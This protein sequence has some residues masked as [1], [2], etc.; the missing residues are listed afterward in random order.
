MMKYDGKEKDRPEACTKPYNEITV[1]ETFQKWHGS[2]A[3]EDI[4][5]KQ[6]KNRN[7]NISKHDS[8][9]MWSPHYST[10]GGHSPLPYR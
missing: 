2:H 3:S 6:C 7:K 4:N 8:S 5:M 1:Y 10:S 9:I